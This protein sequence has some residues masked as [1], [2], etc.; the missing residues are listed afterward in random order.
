MTYELGVKVLDAL[1]LA[2][3]KRL[4]PKRKLFI[5]PD[6]RAQLA[7]TGI[8]GV[9]FVQLDFFAVQTNP[10]PELPV[11]GPRELHPGEGAR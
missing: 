7:S 8:T 10:P 9:K 4:G 2:V 5:P 1:G 3:E 6:L 11:P